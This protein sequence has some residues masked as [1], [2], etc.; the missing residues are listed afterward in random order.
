MRL[1]RR[2]PDPKDNRQ[3]VITAAANMRLL[4]D[5]GPGTGKTELACTRLAH[6]VQHQGIAPDRLLVISFTRLAVRAV[7]ERMLLLLG[8]AAMVRRLRLVTLDA[9]AAYLSP[10]SDFEDDHD[11]AIRQVLPLVEGHPLIGRKAHVIVDEA[12]DIVGPRADLVMELIRCVP[13]TCGVTVLTDDAQSIYGFADHSRW[14]KP[15]LPQRLRPLSWPRAELAVQHRAENQNISQ[16]F[17]QARSAVMDQ[18]DQPDRQMKTLNTILRRLPRLDALPDP[19]MLD[20]ECL[21]LWRHRASVIL[22]AQ[23]YA[24]LGMKFRLRLGNQPAILPAWI[25]LALGRVETPSISRTHFSRLWNTYVDGTPHAILQPDTAWRHLHRAAGMGSILSLRRLRSRLLQA[26]PPLDLTCGTLGQT[27]PVLGT[28]HASKGR[29]ALRVFMAQPGKAIEPKVWFV[30]ATRPRR[31]LTLL[32][33]ET[34]NLNYL[35]SGRCHFPELGAVEL[36]MPGDI[37]P[38]GEEQAQCRLAMGDGTLKMLSDGSL[39]LEDQCL[40]KLSEN[41][42]FDFHQAGLNRFPRQAPWIGVRTLV[43]DPDPMIAMNGPWATSGLILAPII[44][45]VSLLCSQAPA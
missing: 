4:V 21:L 2:K 33:P 45:G 39:I 6:L 9:L 19:E 44:S 34:N 24:Q 32:P 7:A 43:F 13:P 35:A 27:G 16:L 20:E 29:E 1:F 31:S 18:P 37:L 17:T 8:D 41:A 36:G 40:A 5:G 15:A 30:G 26:S 11:G 14:P 23:H 10:D 12:H 42:L 38:L 28:I 3:E 25:A 22:A